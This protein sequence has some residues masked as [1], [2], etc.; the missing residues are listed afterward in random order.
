MKKPFTKKNVAEVLMEIQDQADIQGNIIAT[1]ALEDF[2][3]RAKF[4]T[5]EKRYG[6]CKVYRNDKKIMKATGKIKHPLKAVNCPCCK[7]K[8]VL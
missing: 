4:D 3:L 7:P 6:V 5:P 1:R 2:G 8:K